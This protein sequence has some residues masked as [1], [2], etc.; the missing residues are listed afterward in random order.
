[1]AGTDNHDEQ[2]QKALLYAAGLCA[3]G[4][5]C[6]SDLRTKL[7]RR[8]LSDEEAEGVIR[9]L[10]RHRYVDNHRYACAYVRTK[11]KIAHWGPWKIRQGLVAKG[12]DRETIADAMQQVDADCYMQSACKAA[13][14]KAQRLDL[15]KPADR[16]KLYRHLM[17]K[18]FD[19]ATIT[20]AIQHLTNIV[21]DVQ[22]E[23][24]WEQ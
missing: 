10:R 3:R 19:T 11:S 22:P 5:Q 24:A 23:S 1:M 7:R 14:A 21:D 12:I 6:E 13:K 2:L 15:S 8:E 9:Y 20:A 18:G 17:S 16:L 4:E